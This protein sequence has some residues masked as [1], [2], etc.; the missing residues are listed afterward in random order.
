MPLGSFTE[1][2]FDGSLRMSV[3]RASFGL[4]FRAGTN[5]KVEPMQA[6]FLGRNRISK[7]WLFTPPLHGTW[8][9]VIAI[10]GIFIPTIIRLGMTPGIDD[11]ACTIFCPFV[12]IVSLL[13]G[14]RY[15]LATAVGSAIACNT[16]LMGTPYAFHFTRAEFERISIFLGYSV[17]LITVVYFFRKTA[18]RSLRQA[19]AREQEGGVVFSLDSGQVWASW[20]GVDAPVRLGP[21]KDVVFMMEDFIA[22]MELGKRLLNRRK[23]AAMGS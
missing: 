23:A 8:A 14:W 10:A 9:A 19:G 20:Y 11:Q 1:R 13:G 6:N 22:Q 18:A 4:N 16:L 3:P 12:L 21:P 17:F 7:S 2:N 15:A 5:Q